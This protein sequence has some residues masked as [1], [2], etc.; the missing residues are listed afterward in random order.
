LCSTRTELFETPAS[1]QTVI[2]NLD[3][4]DI[5]AN[6]TQAGGNDEVWFHEGTQHYYLAARGTITNGSVTPILGTVD[7]KTSTTAHSVAADKVSH[8][9]FVPIGYVPSG[10]PA[11]TDST[12]PCP[13]TGCIA[14][15]LPSSIDDDD[16]T[17]QAKR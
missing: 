2:I 16:G 17:K 9:V 1:T 7:A 13:T 3:N 6:I 5:L 15:F 8:H 12:N 14:V 11:G 4:G 10:S